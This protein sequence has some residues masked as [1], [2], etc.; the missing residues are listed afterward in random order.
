M[1]WS[2]CDWGFYSK[3]EPKPL[4]QGSPSSDCFQK[5]QTPRYVE[6]LGDDNPIK[7]KSWHLHHYWLVC[8][9]SH[10]NNGRCG[11]HTSPRPISALVGRWCGCEYLG[12]HSN[13]IDLQGHQYSWACIYLP[14]STGRDNVITPILVSEL[15]KARGSVVFSTDV[16]NCRQ[17]LLWKWTLAGDQ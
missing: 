13:R 3:D 5:S 6:C 10:Q 2:L 1:R 9:T 17:L 16:E 4:S 14:R 8:G 11:W 15:L 7:C 12:L